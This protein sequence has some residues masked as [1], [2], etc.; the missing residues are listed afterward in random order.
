M[1]LRGLVRGEAALTLTLE[2]RMDTG[3][4]LYAIVICPQ[5]C[6]HDH[7]GTHETD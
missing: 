4:C 1:N 6:P 2:T 5:M 3:L 7:Q